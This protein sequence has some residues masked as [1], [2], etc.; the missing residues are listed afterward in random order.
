M[1]FGNATFRTRPRSSAGSETTM[2]SINIAG[3]T[4]YCA[5]QQAFFNP[6]IQLI[7]MFTQPRAVLLMGLV[8]GLSL[9]GADFVVRKRIRY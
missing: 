1:W 8:S 9:C 7:H 4:G 6:L 2:T 3:A 5:P